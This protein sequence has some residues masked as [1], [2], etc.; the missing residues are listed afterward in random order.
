MTVCVTLW[1]LGKKKNVATQTR[2][3]D[4]QD[5]DH[6]QRSSQLLSCSSAISGLAQCAGGA[7]SSVPHP[8]PSASSAWAMQW[9]RALPG[10]AQARLATAATVTT[11]STATTTTTATDTRRR[12]HWFVLDLDGSS[13]YSYFCRSHEAHT[14]IIIIVVLELILF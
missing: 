12:R 14:H 11:R 9:V 13:T 1:T 3:T 6:E 4:H 7:M 8:R 10:R 2:Q 5:H